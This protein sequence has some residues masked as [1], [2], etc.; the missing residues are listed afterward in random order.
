MINYSFKLTRVLLRK[1]KRN[2]FA[3]QKQSVPMSINEFVEMTIF[4]C[5]ICFSIYD[6]MQGFIDESGLFIFLFIY[7]FAFYQDGRQKWQENNFCKK[8][9]V[10]SADTLWVKN[11]S[12]LIYLAPFPR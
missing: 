2:C 9:P 8:S 3:Q 1:R 5:L 6:K 12:K 11:L 10:D 4:L 7:I